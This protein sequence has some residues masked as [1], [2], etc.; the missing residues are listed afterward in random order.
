[1]SNAKWVRK[2]PSKCKDDEII[3]TIV[4]AHLGIDERKLMDSL[5]APGFLLL[6]YERFGATAQKDGRRNTEA[7]ESLRTPAQSL[8]PSRVTK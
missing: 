4:R 5:K 2:R 3:F 7:K 1:M 6:R 8:R